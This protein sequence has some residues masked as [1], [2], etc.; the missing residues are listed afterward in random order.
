MRPVRL[1]LLQTVVASLAAVLCFPVWAQDRSYAPMSSTPDIAVTSAATV[2]MS[3]PQRARWL[4]IRPLCAHTSD[5]VHFDLQ[6]KSGDGANDFN[7]TIPSSADFT[8]SLIIAGLSAS[9]D[10]NALGACTVTVI[11]AD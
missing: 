5:V 11:F 9:A 3:P 6:G 4:H 7:L 1:R 2:D 8:A 10:G